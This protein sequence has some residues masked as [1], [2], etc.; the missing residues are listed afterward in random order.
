M[1]AF[2]GKNFKTMPPLG[3]L[4][5]PQSNN[6]ANRCLVSWLIMFIKTIFFKKVLF[7]R[8]APLFPQNAPLFPSRL[9]ARSVLQ[10][11][12]KSSPNLQKQKNVC[13]DSTFETEP[14]PSPGLLKYTRHAQGFWPCLGLHGLLFFSYSISVIKKTDG[15]K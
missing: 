10:T 4:L 11:M 6:V 9:Q 13:F 12:H 1:F 2:H 8:D 14:S 15:G 3:G 7:W 5:A